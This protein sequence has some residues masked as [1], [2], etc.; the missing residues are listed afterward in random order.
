MFRDVPSWTT[1]ASILL[2]GV[3]D[4]TNHYEGTLGMHTP[5][6]FTSSPGPAGCVRVSYG[7]GTE[8]KNPPSFMVVAAA[9]ALYAGASDLGRRL[10]A[11]LSSRHPPCAR[12]PADRQRESQ[13]R[14]RG[15]PAPGTGPDRRGQRPAI[16][17]SDPARPP[18]KRASSHSRR[19]VRHAARGPGTGSTSR[20]REQRHA[21]AVR[22][23]CG[24][25]AASA[26]SAWSPGAWRS[27]ACASSN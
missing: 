18:W 10:P 13:G 4:H 19:H 26:G 22:P 1:C 8:N 11:R 27:A 25:Y 5:A 23:G 7:L 3:L 15:P 12:T 16:C 9:C 6:S 17:T 21:Q 20:K 14:H 24:R 2:A